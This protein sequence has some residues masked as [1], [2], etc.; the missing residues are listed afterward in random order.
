MESQSVDAGRAVVWYSFGWRMFMANPV[1]WVV[2]MLLIFVMTFI[3]QIIPLVGPVVL[4]LI[5]PALTGGLMYG[6]KQGAE[7]RTIKISHLFQPLIDEHSR[8]PMLVLGAVLLGLSILLVIA[9]AIIIGGS[10][11]IGIFGG[12]ADDANHTMIAIGAMG[13][14]VALMLVLSL[15][16]GLV[17]FAALA[18][19]VP[20]VLFNG[21][22]PAAAVKSSIGVSIK[23]TVPLAVF[24][25][26][27]FVLAVIAAIPM[28]LGFLVLTPVTVAALYAGY[29]D[30]SPPEITGSEVISA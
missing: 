27:Y 4:S 21:A 3:L 1:V 17:T 5:F 19:A 13:I 8:I 23:N 2:M 30:I 10:A 18:F 16:Y 15:A 6:A 9:A 24:L 25:V 29:R 7:G 26:I 12:N 11:G 22:S 14:G 20:L 28:F